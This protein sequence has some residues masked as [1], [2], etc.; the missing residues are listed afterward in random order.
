MKSLFT[1]LF[2]MIPSL[3]YGFDPPGWVLGQSHPQFPKGEYIVGVGISQKNMVAAGDS[4]RMELAKKIKV[5]IRS[6]MYDLST[7]NY[8]ISESI[9]QTDVDS[10]L[11]GIEISDGWYDEDNKYYY[12]LATLNRDFA[13]VV[14]KDTMEELLIS[15]EEFMNDGIMELEEGNYDIAY[16]LFMKGRELAEQVP[17]LKGILRFL[18]DSSEYNPKYKDVDFS[19]HLKIAVKEKRNHA[20][21]QR[22]KIRSAWTEQ[23]H[24][25]QPAPQ[26]IW[27]ELDREANT[28]TIRAIGKKC[29]RNGTILRECLEW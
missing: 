24:K 11:E 29:I 3:V 16:R 6:T 15:V 23:D 9:I 12:S 14:M 26:D 7:R 8:T 27:E 5:E 21:Q 22:E 20:R 2:I 19:R 13:A 10:I 18:G 17:V 1:L 4:A 28:F 25:S